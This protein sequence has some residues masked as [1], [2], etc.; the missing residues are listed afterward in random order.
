MTA[1]RF[2]CVIIALYIFKSTFANLVVDHLGV[3][4][5]CALQPVQSVNL[6]DECA[7]D[8]GALWIIGGKI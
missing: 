3:E 5:A 1:R 7:V 6:F 2:F 8:R 4:R